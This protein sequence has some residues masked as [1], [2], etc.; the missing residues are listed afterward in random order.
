MQ[1]THQSRLRGNGGGTG[2][3]GDG[4]T[5][6]RGDEGG[7]RGEGECSCLR[8]YYEITRKPVD[9]SGKLPRIYLNQYTKNL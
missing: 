5:G 1:K 4:G 3:R 9:T 7:G 2:G 8:G 6:G